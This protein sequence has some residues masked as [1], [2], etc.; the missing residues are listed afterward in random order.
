MV[1]LYCSVLSPVRLYKA[2]CL[3]LL[4]LYMIYWH[5]CYRHKTNKTDKKK[6]G[7]ARQNVNLCR[8]LL[9][10][11]ALLYQCFRTIDKKY[12]LHECFSPDLQMELQFHVLWGINALDGKGDSFSNL[13][14]N[15]VWFVHCFFC[16]WEA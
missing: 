1:H 4:S 15:Q 7:L 14:P 10:M 12:N 3:Y 16:L 11:K 2:F 9:Q 6:A 8:T 5:L 13:F